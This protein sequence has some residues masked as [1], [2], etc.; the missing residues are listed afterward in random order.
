MGCI[1]APT[2]I[3]LC[4]A[5]LQP[6]EVASDYAGWIADSQVAV[7]DEAEHFPRYGHADGRSRFTRDLAGFAGSE[8]V[9]P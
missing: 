1:A 4:A 5:D 8:R 9:E 7:I 2:P 6:M 3:I